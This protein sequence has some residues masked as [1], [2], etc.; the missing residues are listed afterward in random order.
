M[1]D[2]LIVAEELRGWRHHL[3]ANP[4]LA[5]QEHE[6]A[7]FVAERLKEFGF[8]EIETGIGGTGVVATLR[9]GT[10]SRSIGLRADM[11]ALPIQEGQDRGHRSRRPGVMHACGH[12][13]H[14]T[15]LLGA[16]K[17][18]AAS[19]GFDGTIRFVF[20]PAE[21]T[22][23]YLSR[24]GEHSGGA[25]AMIDDGLFERFPMDAIFG[26]H[27]RPGLPVGTIAG[28]PGIVYA[29]A[30]RFDIE[31]IGRGG[32]AARPHLTVDPVMVGAQ[33]IVALQTVVSRMVS[34]T[35]SGVVSVCE[36][37]AGSGFNVIPGSARL[38][39]T[40]RSL[41]SDTRARIRKGMEDVTAGVAATFGAQITL[42]YLAGH[43]S[44]SN[45]PELFEIC[46]TVGE[47][48]VG[49]DAFVHLDE[50]T[51]GGE[52]FSC[53]L[54]HRPGCFMLI[55]ND[56][57]NEP[58]ASLHNARYD[59]NDDAAPVGVRYWVALARALLPEDS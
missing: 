55:G 12:D 30:D 26:V 25:T 50:P 9:A 20:Q 54:R 23:G 57:T 48:V 33:L 36:F 13:G 53:Y 58:S 5:F 2:N 52:D 32:H 28:R 49:A 59:F 31:V 21:E 47:G 18:L 27:N 7:A 37:H 39:G 24:S 35:D 34:P 42:D 16:A 6:T 44:V 56:G 43:P 1:H 45:D 22:L 8:G 17:V 41:S 46:R 14:V 29:A 51:M 11:D 10:S 4:E 19:G 15:M 38:T 40:V 3:H